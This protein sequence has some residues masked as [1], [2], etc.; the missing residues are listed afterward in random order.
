MLHIYNAKFVIVLERVSVPQDAALQPFI[1][2][3]R[4]VRSRGGTVAVV[5]EDNNQLIVLK[6]K[7][8]VEVYKSVKEIPWY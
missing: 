2:F 3:I 1:E 6:S 8:N 5:A 4:I 7:L